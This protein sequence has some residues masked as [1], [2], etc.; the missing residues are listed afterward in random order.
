MRLRAVLGPQN[1]S[2]PRTQPSPLPSAALNPGQL[3]FTLHDSHWPAPPALAPRPLLLCPSLP[4][5][6]SVCSTHAAEACRPVG[7][8]HVN[9]SGRSAPS[10]PF[11]RA[12]WRGVCVQDG[13]MRRALRRPRPPLLPPTAAHQRPVYVHAALNFL[14]ESFVS[15]L[16]FPF[17]LQVGITDV[18][19]NW[20]PRHAA[21]VSWRLGPRMVF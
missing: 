1:A 6:S 19:K 17:C 11:P 7:P 9:T 2:S 5:L 13:R 4:S 3:S 12:A 10:C 18:M 21:F 15:L 20:M 8:S 16:S 14:L